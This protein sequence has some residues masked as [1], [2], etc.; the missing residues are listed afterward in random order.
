MGLKTALN[1]MLNQYQERTGIQYHLTYHLVDEELP[2]NLE[3]TLYR[4][5]QEALTNTEKHADAQKITLHLQ[6]VDNNIVLTI[7]DDGN[8]FCLQQIRK[9]TGIG[10]QNM[11]E[12]IE[13]LAGTFHLETSQKKGTYI[14]V[15]LPQEKH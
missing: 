12:R 6:S 4:V 5:V 13:L 3:I 8:G 9:K 10:L 15:T 1:S 11:R 14:R 7:N 2:D